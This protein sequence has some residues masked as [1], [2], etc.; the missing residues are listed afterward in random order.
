MQTHLSANLQRRRTAHARSHTLLLHR[1]ICQTSGSMKTCY[2]LIRTLS[3]NT[4]SPRWRKTKIKMQSETWLY[5]Q[6]GKNKKVKPSWWCVYSTKYGFDWGFHTDTWELLYSV[7][8]FIQRKRGKAWTNMTG[9]LHRQRCRICA[10]MPLLSNVKHYEIQIIS[11]QSVKLLLYV[12]QI[13]SAE[14]G[15]TRLGPTREFKMHQ[16]FLLTLS[17]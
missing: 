9:R 5:M 14:W 15:P 12:K 2:S 10:H 6:R 16:A 17:V 8:L 4:L 11:L 13:K 1:P 7:S 3:F